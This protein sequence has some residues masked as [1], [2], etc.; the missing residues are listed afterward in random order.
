MK[1]LRLL[2][3]GFIALI[4][5]CFGVFINLWHRVF[6]SQTKPSPVETV[7]LK[8]TLTPHN[9]YQHLAATYYQYVCDAF[10]E[11][12][13][14]DLSQYQLH[15]A[16]FVAW[17]LLN[18]GLG[19]LTE[20]QQGDSHPSHSLTYIMQLSHDHWQCFMMERGSVRTINH[21]SSK[22]AAIRSHAMQKWDNLSTYIKTHFQK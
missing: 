11:I 13:S 6:A 1:Q 16:D 7:P 9:F 15:K 12:T 8:L 14:H 20:V 21:F 3:H 5:L 4:V 19:L 22:E 17:C 2:W 18:D 10:V